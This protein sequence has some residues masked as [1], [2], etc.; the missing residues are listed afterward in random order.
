MS[1]SKQTKAKATFE[2]KTW[3]EKPYREFDG[4][5]K[6]TRVKVTV[7][8]HGDIEGEGTLEYL[9]F[10]P[11]D[12]SASIVGLEHVIGRI[13]DRAGSFVLQHTGTDDGSAT[14]SAYFVVPGSGTGD[15][16]GLRGKGRSV[17]SR[18]KPQYSM[19]LNY[20]FE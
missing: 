16:H 10:Y 4:G 7:S 19:P 18:N 13:G 2:V 20:N 3:D 12:G 15:L 9:M 6:F 8:I 1:T 14:R 11:G 17:L 5:A